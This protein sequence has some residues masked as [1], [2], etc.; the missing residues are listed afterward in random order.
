MITGLTKQLQVFSGIKITLSLRADAHTGVAIR[1]PAQNPAS[2]P[3][4]PFGG[5]G[6]ARPTVFIETTPTERYGLPRR[7]A[8]RNDSGGRN[9]VINMCMLTQLGFNKR[10]L[11]PRPP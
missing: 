11:H 2:K 8:P 1:A 9:T 4:L 7:F 10:Q 5:L 3:P 6:S